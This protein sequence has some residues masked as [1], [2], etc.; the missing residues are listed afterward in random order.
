MV[1]EPV[2]SVRGLE[3]HYPIGGGMFQGEVG[4]VRAVDG[5][6]FEVHGGE[7]LGLVGESGCGKSTAAASLLRLEEPTAGEVRFRGEDI[8][9][10]DDAQLKRFRRKAQMVFQ[11]PTS[12]FDPRMSVGDSVAEPLLIH[13]MRDRSRRRTIVANLLE[14]VGMDAADYD[15]Y[16]HEFSGGQKQRIALARALVL[17][18]DLLV[19]D[20]P[21]SALDVSVQA[22]I[23]KLIQ[24]VQSAFGLSILLISHDMGVVREICDRVAVMYLGEIVE[25]GPTEKLFED[26]QHPYTRALMRS[27][28]SADPRRRGRAV[29]LTGSVPSPSNPPSGCRFHT[30]CPEVIQPEGFEFDQEQWRAVMDFRDSV[31]H[32]SI[33][34]EAAREFLAAEGDVDP[35][36]VESDALVA[37]LREEAELEEPLGDPDADRALSTAFELVADGEF[38]AAADRLGETF[39]TVCETDE[40]EL[41]ADWLGTADLRRALSAAAGSDGTR[42]FDPDAVREAA[43]TERD[44]DPAALDRAT[45]AAAVRERYGIPATLAEADAEDAVSRAIDAALEARFAEAERVLREEFSVA[46]VGIG[47]DDPDTHHAAACH[48]LEEWPAG[49]GREQPATDD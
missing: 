46:G 48:L 44:V 1:G 8:T 5:V 26:A 17:N 43:A 22:S 14:R 12:T 16:P 24:D 32:R 25:I 20:E 36:A 13:G 11:D 18:P 34:L 7:T 41:R 9:T 4:R 33:D 27:I 45:V 40:P 39:T 30:R 31:A 6:D 35:E 42:A 47:P 29:E 38:E 10:Y 23:L 3:K 21:V 49:T 15:R 19:A 37:F 2:L 28:P